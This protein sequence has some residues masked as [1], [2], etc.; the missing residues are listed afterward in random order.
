M[1]GL[2]ARI[3]ALGAEGW[4]VSELQFLLAWRGFP[5]GSFDGRFGPSL[6][7]AVRRFQRFAGVPLTGVV[8]QQT[9]AALRRPA[10]SSPLRLELP[11]AAPV[12]DGFGPRDDRFHAGIDFV[13]APGEPVGAARGG[14][15]VWAAPRGS[16]GNA[17]VIAHGS[18]VRPLYAHLSRITVGVGVRVAVRMTCSR[19]GS[20]GAGDGAVATGPVR[21]R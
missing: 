13:A 5:S 4:D 7:A 18:G 17:I 15:V 14:C 9:L 8:A 1:P 3:L 20:G 12:G 6:D 19:R 2:G 11:V 16:F 10:P 21:S